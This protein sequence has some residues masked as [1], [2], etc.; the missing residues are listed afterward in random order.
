MSNFL[1]KR[2][3]WQPL[4]LY[5][6]DGPISNGN[7]IK[8]RVPGESCPFG[9]LQPDAELVTSLNTASS[10][11]QLGV[12]LDEAPNNDTKRVQLSSISSVSA[13][14]FFS[15]AAVTNS[16]LNGGGLTIELVVRLQA[17]TNHSMTLLSIANELD[18]CVDS[19][20]RLDVNE[21]KVLAFLYS[22]PVLEEGGEACYEQRLF[23]VN[24]AAK[25]QLPVEKTP[26][27]HITVTLD[28]SEKGLWRTSFYVS[29]TDPDS[30][31]R[32][33]CEVHDEQHPP[34]TQVLSK[35]IKGR[36]RLYLGNSPRN[37]TY[38][39]QR[40]H[41]AP[42]RQF[43]SF[44][45]TSM[46]ATERLRAILKQKLE[47]IRGP[48]LPKAMRIFGDNSLSLNI[49][50]I[51]FPPLNEDTPLAYLRSQFADFKE[52]YGDQIV[53]Y[54]VNLVLQKAKGPIVTN[55]GQ[56]SSDESDKF[57]RASLF[58]SAGGSTFD[59]FHVAIYR[60]VVS[61]EEVASISR[62]LLLPCR[63][64]PSL[65]QTVRIPED[66]LVLLNLTLFDGVFN[67]LRLELRDLPEFGRLLLFPSRTRPEPDQNNENLPLPNPVAFSRRLKPYAT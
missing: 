6:F 31:Q 62:E 33:D 60:H 19:G 44:G 40:R 20:F 35:L 42:T 37:V 10:Y 24:N 46:N 54:L 58:Q 59:L 51:T 27:V 55:Q 48:Q 9:T 25:C 16:S 34:S 26:A 22:L 29:Y 39:R 12:R 7:T 53:D 32:V 65:R 13:R 14:E 45:S 52:K 38:P 8:N 43:D 18:D 64:F 28:P 49:L 36:Y 2:S 41:L 47:S 66:S 23:S 30:M 3:S 15:M 50:G 21:H 57:S 5:T 67:D 61:E 4:C 11:W 17:E 63:H 1:S 56:D